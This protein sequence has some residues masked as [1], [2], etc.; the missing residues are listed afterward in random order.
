MA[1]E[2]GSLTIL[3]EELAKVDQ[4]IEN[5]TEEVNDLKGELAAVKHNLQQI[6]A[7]LK[8]NKERKKAIGKQ[9]TS[10]RKDMSSK[11]IHLTTEAQL[12]RLNQERANLDKIVADTSNHDIYELAVALSIRN[13]YTG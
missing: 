4:L 9:Q 12:Q 8:R 13:D 6:E 7:R 11:T 1:V 10:L 3:Y 2:L 5:D